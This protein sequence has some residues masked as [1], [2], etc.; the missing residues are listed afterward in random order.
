MI[1]CISCGAEYDDDE[2]IYTCE[3]GSILEV[4]TGVDNIPKETF[5]NRR[6]NIW[7]YKEFLPVNA[8]NRIK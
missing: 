6:D 3:C 2:I 5:D 1:R 8:E 4:V 7:K